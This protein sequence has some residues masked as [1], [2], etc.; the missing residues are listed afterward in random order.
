MNHLSFIILG[1]IVSG[2]VIALAVALIKF[3]IK[4]RKI[5]EYATNASQE[6]LG[7]IYTAIENS[8]TEQPTSAVLARSGLKSESISFQ[9]VIPEQIRPWGGMSVLSE[10]GDN[11]H[12]RLEH[13]HENLCILRN[14]IYRPVYVPRNRT[15]SGK[16]RNTYSTDAYF[17]AIPSVADECKKIAPEYPR[18][19]LGYLFNTSIESHEF[20]PIFQVRFGGSASWIQDPEFVNCPI[21]KKRM[22]LIVQIPGALLPGK[23]S[24]KGNYYLQGCKTHIEQTS[25]LEQF[26]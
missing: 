21:C 11:V 3:N 10:I 22:D 6:Q 7:R 16:S 14:T 25:T 20:D 2:L 23:V 17:K 18:E 15:K 9:L 19:L 12:L 8:G 4:R 26:T 24:D 5:I 1:T 13:T